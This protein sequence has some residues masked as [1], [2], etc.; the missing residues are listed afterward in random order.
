MQSP[1]G[2]LILH[3]AVSK[4]NNLSCMIIAHT[5]QCDPDACYQAGGR[6]IPDA[7][8]RKCLRNIYTPLG[9]RVK[10]WAS[11]TDTVE[12]CQY[13]SCVQQSL[14]ATINS[15]KKRANKSDENFTKTKEVT[16]AAVRTSTA[17]AQSHDLHCIMKNRQH[18]VCKEAECREEGG[19]CLAK[20]WKTSA[21]CFSHV[22]IDGK[23]QARQFNKQNDL[24]PSCTNCSCVNLDHFPRHATIETS[25]AYGQ[26]PDSDLCGM[27]EK[28]GKVCNDVECK[29]DGGRCLWRQQGKISICYQ[30]MIVD[31]VLIP[32]IFDRGDPKPSC[33]GCKCARKDL[34]DEEPAN[35]PTNKLADLDCKMAN[36]GY[37]R[38]C[39]EAEC[40]REG[41]RCLSVPYR[42]YARC[43][44][45]IL[46]D[47]K[48]FRHAFQESTVLPSCTNCK[49][50]NPAGFS[51]EKN[52]AGK[53]KFPE[54]LPTSSDEVLQNIDQFWSAP[55]VTSPSSDIF[56]FPF[57]M[58]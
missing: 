3:P 39:K 28:E 53:R 25:A 21:R 37:N 54:Q 33:T 38:R 56:N 40:E 18:L 32:H 34:M 11:H 48:L 22:W 46:T 43:Y 4:V 10:S 51:N 15:G 49:C 14:G 6:C 1:A 24:L 36:R 52:M 12:P 58:L 2:A 45:H 47:G 35:N 50:I 41:G 27:V 8:N 5:L 23:L 13:C 55:E 30:H 26:F 17:E 20:P 9:T 57:Q 31:G 19:L 29:K 42:G 16:P 7:K 44:P